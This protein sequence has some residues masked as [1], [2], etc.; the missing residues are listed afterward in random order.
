MNAKRQNTYG[1]DDA[2]RQMREIAGRDA[3]TIMVGPVLVYG[4]DDRLMSMIV[5]GPPGNIDSIDFGHYSEELSGPLYDAVPIVLH[6]RQMGDRTLA[7]AR[8]YREKLIS[9]FRCHFETVRVFED[10]LELAQAAA[11]TFPTPKLRGV[12]DTIAAERAASY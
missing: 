4:D 10:E 11:A 6:L 7:E 1:V 2:A 12:A 5:T 3:H 8:E 9:V